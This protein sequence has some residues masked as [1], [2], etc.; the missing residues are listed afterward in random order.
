MEGKEFYCNYVN[1]RNQFYPIP[2]TINNSRF[3][4]RY[5]SNL[6]FNETIEKVSYHENYQ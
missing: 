3:S 6:T 2:N 5:Y 1:Y 4:E